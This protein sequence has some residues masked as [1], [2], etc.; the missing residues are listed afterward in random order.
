MLMQRSLLAIKIKVVPEH[1]LGILKNIPKTHMIK[2]LKV[3]DYSLAFFRFSSFQERG[4]WTTRL[5][6]TTLLKSAFV[7][8]ELEFRRCDL[9]PSLWLASNVSP[10][11]FQAYFGSPKKGLWF[12]FTVH[13]RGTDTPTVVPLAQ[14]HQMTL[15]SNWTDRISRFTPHK[16]TSD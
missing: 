10:S 6:G 1:R 13:G 11:P 8:G 7:K 15:V 3:S 9:I 14:P 2:G 5:G 4:S 16:M 12:L